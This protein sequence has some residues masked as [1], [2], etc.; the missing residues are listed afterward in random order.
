MTVESDHKPLETIFK[1]PLNEAPPRLQRMLL[2]LQ[3][4]CLKIVYKPGKLLHIADT[5]SRAAVESGTDSE[6]STDVQV[7]I[8][9]LYDNLEAS[10]EKLDQIRMETERDSALQ[11]VIGYYYNGWPE[12]I[13]DVSIEGRQF[14]TERNELHVINGVL[15]RNNRIVIPKSLRSE[16]L[17]RIHE[18]HLGI[19]KSKRRARDVMWC[20]GC[21]EKLKQ[22]Y[23][24][25]S[26]ACA[27]EP[28][29]RG[30]PLR[31]TRCRPCLG[32]F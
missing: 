16:M 5:L 19:E 1:K 12:S 10:S 15:F 2:R 6:I 13:K 22:R 9:T 30:S 24:A 21:P 32:K 23:S 17:T 28:R 11:C 29:R 14:W 26:R 20:L 31:P 4:Y 25:V 18:G 3:A 7:H 27:T 8:N